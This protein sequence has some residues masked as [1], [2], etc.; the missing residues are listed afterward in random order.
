MKL[1]HLVNNI[2]SA[3]KAANNLLRDGGHKTISFRDLETLI[4]VS[5]DG[6]KGLAKLAKLRGV[7]SAAITGAIDALEKKE[8]ALREHTAQDRR[9]IPVRLTP[10]GDKVLKIASD[11]I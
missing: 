5:I 6:A 3:L 2:N 9:V 8:L 1:L 11:A 4:F 7:S 10:L